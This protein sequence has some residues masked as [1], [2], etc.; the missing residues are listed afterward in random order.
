MPTE[1]FR[2]WP[3]RPG[4]ELADMIEVWIEGNSVPHSMKKAPPV[5]LRR[6]LAMLEET[7]AA[8]VSWMGVR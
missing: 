4:L 8:A 5:P 7:L 3:V 6:W 2:L 1:P